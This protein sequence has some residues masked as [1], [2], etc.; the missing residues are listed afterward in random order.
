MSLPRAQP[1]P[2]AVAQRA[3]QSPVSNGTQ[4][5]EK[6]KLI[7]NNEYER[8]EL[9]GGGS[10]GYVYKCKHVQTGQYYAIKYFKNKFATMKKAFD[11][12]EI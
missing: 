7:V 1:P 9:I 2:G 11:Q 3:E 10:F 12:R 5:P 6:P 4:S 8:E